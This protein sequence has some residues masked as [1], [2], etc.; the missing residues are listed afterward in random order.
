MGGRRA[1]IASAQTREG[2]EGVSTE[3]ATLSG[4]S[5]V[6]FR[7]GDPDPIGQL[8]AEAASRMIRR[9]HSFDPKIALSRFENRA[10]RPKP[11]LE[12]PKI[13]R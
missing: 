1:K 10:D 3:V 5:S 6:R 9:S 13:S 4:L 11:V 2:P 8:S 12:D 7:A